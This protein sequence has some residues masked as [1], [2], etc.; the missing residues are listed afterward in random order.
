MLSELRNLLASVCGIAA[1][2]GILSTSCA[3]NSPTARPKP[4]WL[5]LAHDDTGDFGP[6]TPGTKTAGWQEALDDCVAQS[7]DLYV[8]GG[9]GGRK[10]VYH[11]DETIRFP[12]AQDFKIDGGVYVINF[13]GTKTDD[14]AVVIDS[15]MNC[16][17]K[18]GIIVYGGKGAG[19]RI[20]PEKPVPI[21]GFP[22]V[23]ETLISSQGIADPQPF[24]AGQRKAGRGLVLDSSQASISYSKFDFAAVLNFSTNIQ[25]EG[26]HGFFSNTFTCE[27]LH[28]NAH[29]SSL[30]A[31]GPQATA[32]T[33]RFGIG[34][35]QGASGVQGIELLGARNTLDVSTRLGGFSPARQ[36][37][38]SPSAHGNQINLRTAADPL[39]LITDR[40]EQPTNQITWTGP[41]APIQRIQ[42]KPGS[43]V[44]VQRLFPAVVS[45]TGTESS[46]VVFERSGESID[47]GFA[48][49]RDI[50][51]SVG[52]R[53]RIDG[54]T[55][56]ALVVV[57]F[58][59]R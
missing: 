32:N 1:V 25:I 3:E 2:L 22:V 19:L 4:P 13:R 11:I 57:P 31:I 28:T 33:F 17:Y 46:R 40:A 49:D 10:A 23:I 15:A 34:V 52:D 18:L 26:R 21:D 56:P 7:K 16:E 43:Y 14:D 41:P 54:K 39:T 55:A 59:T 8:K 42:G 36:L 58:K 27:H 48:Q 38:L 51:M 12:P 24:V 35:D 29:N 6:A 50:L 47:Y 44:Y 37:I 9:Y 20:R 5:V 45:V 30:C 53:L